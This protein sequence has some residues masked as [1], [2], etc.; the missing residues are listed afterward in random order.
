MPALTAP[1]AEE[2]HKE[3]R[4]KVHECAAVHAC[5]AGHLP[6][7]DLNLL[8]PPPLAFPHRKALYEDVQGVGCESSEEEGGEGEWTCTPDAESPGET[9]EVDN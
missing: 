2:A 3:Q 5:H 9:I 8:S 4:A 7:A 1:Q 6:Y